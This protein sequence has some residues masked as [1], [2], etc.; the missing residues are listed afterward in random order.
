MGSILSVQWRSNCPPIPT[1][2]PPTHP[3]H[4]TPTTTPVPERLS[5]WLRER[6][7]QQCRG[8]ADKPESSA[9]CQHRG[10]RVLNACAQ[11]CWRAA[12]HSVRVSL[13]VKSAQVGHAPRH[14]RKCGKEWSWMS[15]NFLKATDW[16]GDRT[17]LS[18]QSHWSLSETTSKHK[19]KRG[20]KK[21]RKEKRKGKNPQVTSTWWPFPR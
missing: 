19:R 15:R 4:T 13:E 9:G 14:F 11:C 20:G 5:A 21:S 16:W 6:W 8:L 12:S 3:P 17:T 2:H 7:S 10:P 18:A 1:T